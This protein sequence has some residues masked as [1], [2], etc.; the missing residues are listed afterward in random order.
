MSARLPKKIRAIITMDLRRLLRDKFLLGTALY[1]MGVAVAL[2]WLVPW[3][4]SRLLEGTGF[5]IATH[6]PMGVSYFV[7]VNSSVLTG[8]LGGFLLLEEREER[9]LPAL[10]VTPTPLAVQLVTLGG[11]IVLAGTLIPIVLSIAIGV[12]VPPLGAAVVTSVAGAPM[13]VALALM[14]ATVATNKVEALAAMKFTSILGLVPVGAYFLPGP[15]QYLAGVVPIYWPCKMWW[16]AAAGETGWAWMIAPAIVT[17]V[18]WIG[19]LA[20]RFS[21]TATG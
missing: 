7:L 10:M 18:V 13:G 3:F 11:M 5:D 21:A 16:L 8:M 20:R 4:Q 14:L 12:G 2:R 15:W 19:V 6:V 1:I 17:S 9:T